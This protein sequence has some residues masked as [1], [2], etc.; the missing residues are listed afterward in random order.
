MLAPTPRVKAPPTHS[1]ERIA[2]FKTQAGGRAH[3]ETGLWKHTCKLGG[4]APA[5]PRRQ[6]H[7]AMRWE[8]EGELWE[9]PPAAGRCRRRRA[10]VAPAAA[11]ASARRAARRQADETRGSCSCLPPLSSRITISTI[12]T[13]RSL[14]RHHHHLLLSVASSNNILLSSLSLSLSLPLFTGTPPRAPE[15]APRARRAAR[16]GA[17]ARRPR[18]RLFRMVAACGMGVGGSVM[19]C[20]GSGGSGRAVH[21]S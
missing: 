6:M 5:V 21:A 18:R 11:H 14:H 13:H 10:A 1:F 15:S 19:W 12:A 20:V 16:A 17:R 9:Q 7:P 2:L 3:G 8:G 4:D